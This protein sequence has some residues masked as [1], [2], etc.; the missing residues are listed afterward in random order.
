MPRLQGDGG[1]GAVKESSDPGPVLSGKRS[2][3]VDG[4]GGEGALQGEGS[5]VRYASLC[6]N[7]HLEGD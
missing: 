5:A 7:A 2:Q 6:C 3:H 4:E 1:G